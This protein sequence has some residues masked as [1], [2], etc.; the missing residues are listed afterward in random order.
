MDTVLKYL[1]LDNKTDNTASFKSGTRNRRESDVYCSF[2]NKF[3]YVM[4]SHLSNSWRSSD[5]LKILQQ[6]T[7]LHH[8]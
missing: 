1:L 7:L 4:L 2:K 3:I 6:V 5:A 8:C